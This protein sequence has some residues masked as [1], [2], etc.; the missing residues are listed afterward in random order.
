MS[1]WLRIGCC[2]FNYFLGPLAKN[3]SYMS[4]TNTFGRVLVSFAQAHHPDECTRIGFNFQH[5]AKWCFKKLFNA[6]AANKSLR[7]EIKMFTIQISLT[8]FHS[9]NSIKSWNALQFSYSVLIYSYH[10]MATNLFHAFGDFLY[11][12]KKWT[13]FSFCSHSGYRIQYA[14]LKLVFLFIVKIV[15]MFYG[16]RL[17]VQ[18]EMAYNR[19][20]ADLQREK[21]HSWDPMLL[22]GSQIIVNF[23]V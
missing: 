13:C 5:S 1:I 16:F 9:W 3:I 10:E 19:Y 2:D 14:N 6:N 4:F 15:K 18:K 17:Q 11:H 22:S 7:Q 23:S 12:P 20:A 21:W 8:M